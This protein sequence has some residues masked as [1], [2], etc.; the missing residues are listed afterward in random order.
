[1][2]YLALS[3]RPQG[4]A[5]TSAGDPGGGLLTKESNFPLLMAMADSRAPV[6]EKVQQLP[7][8]P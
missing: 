3:A 4:R 1:M 8:L 2:A 6:V 7:Q 5:M